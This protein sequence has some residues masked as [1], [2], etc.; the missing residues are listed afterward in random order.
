MRYTFPE[1]MTDNDAMKKKGDQLY[2]ILKKMAPTKF[3][4]QLE[5]GGTTSRYHLQIYLHKSGKARPKA[6]AIQFNDKG[7]AGMRAAAVSTNNIGDYANYC[8]KSE[9]ETYVAGPW[10]YPPKPEEFKP[11]FLLTKEQMTPWQKAV[12]NYLCQEG[13][14]HREILWIYDRIGKHGKGA[15]ANYQEYVNKA[16]CVRMMQAKDMLQN[17]TTEIKNAEYKPKAVIFDIP[18]SVPKGVSGRDIA[19]I[20]EQVK[21]GRFSTPKYESTTLRFQQPKVVVLSANSPWD[22]KGLEMSQDRIKVLNISDEPQVGDPIDPLEFKLCEGA[23]HLKIITTKHQ[24][25][26][27]QQR[28]QEETFN[29]EITDEDLE[30]LFFN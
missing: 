2:E 4:F 24:L 6:F 3:C 8:S 5:K 25:E 21:D 9:D 27:A 17:L 20:L 23:M 19:T 13:T 12:D 18:R 29:V 30:A 26:Q 10:Y 28:Q 11:S 1:D 22:F 7:F 15:F 16:T 14:S